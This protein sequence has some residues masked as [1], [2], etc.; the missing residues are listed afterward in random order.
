MFGAEL[1]SCGVSD[2]R[3]FQPKREISVHGYVLL[4][5]RERRGFDS[6]SPHQ[7]FS[8]R[9]QCTKKGLHNVPQRELM[10]LI[11]W[12]RF[13]ALKAVFDPLR[14]PLATC[15]GTPPHNS[16]NNV[17]RIIHTLGNANS[18]CS[19]VVFLARPR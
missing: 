4:A 10:H 6:P 11:R 15:R 16:C 19:C 1:R 14:G 17:C 18:V 7:L 9:V 13:Q 8:V 3:K 12:R 5:K 2:E